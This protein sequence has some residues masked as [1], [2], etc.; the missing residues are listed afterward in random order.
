MSPD[1][2]PVLLASRISSGA[3]QSSSRTW[4]VLKED[5]ETMMWSRFMLLEEVESEECDLD[6]PAIVDETS[7]R[8]KIAVSTERRVMQCVEALAFLLHETHFKTSAISRTSEYM[9]N[10]S[11]VMEPFSM[12]SWNVLSAKSTADGLPWGF[13]G[14]NISRR[15]KSQGRRDSNQW[16]D[17]CCRGQIVASFA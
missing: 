9:K 11:I 12:T 2:V 10:Q 16:S 17:W 8:R 4:E 3:V 13:H 5:S 14:C 15:T 6:L 1:I 7:V